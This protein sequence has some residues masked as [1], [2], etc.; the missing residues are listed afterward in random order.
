MSLARKK[1]V[2]HFLHKEMET[3]FDRLDNLEKIA[4]GLHE[5]LGLT[6]D[7]VMEVYDFGNVAL[8]GMAGL[9]FIIEYVPGFFQRGE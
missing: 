4:S 6:F 3:V 1:I 8:L 9:A 2:I 7:E 5:A